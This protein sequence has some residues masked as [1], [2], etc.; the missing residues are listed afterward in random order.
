MTTTPMSELPAWPMTRSCPMLPPDAFRELRERPPVKVRMRCGDAWLLTRYQDVRAALADLRLSSDD[1]RPG[2]PSLIQLPDQGL[3]SFFRMDPP[4]A[5]RLR[6]VAMSEFTARRTR[7]LQ[8]TVEQLVGQLLDELGA[9]PRPTDLIEAFTLKL[10]AL[11]IARLLGVPDKDEGTFT[12]QTRTLLSQVAPPEETYAVY[13]AMAKYIDD[14]TAQRE[15]E[16]Q[17][18]MLSRLATQFV[19]TGQVSHHELVEIA[20]LLLIAGHETTANLLSL[21]ALSLLLDPQQRDRILADPEVVEAAVEEF[22]RYWSISQDNIVRVAIEDVEFGDVL[23]RAGEA[24]VLSIPAAN[25]DDRVFTDAAGLD[26]TRANVR[27]HVAFGFGPHL[28]PGAPLARLEMK[29]GLVELFRRFPT[30]RLA[31]DFTEL[32]FREKTLVYGVNKLP[33]TW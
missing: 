8:P 31:V 14:L 29:V 25:H 16:P 4:A 19:A 11:M 12:E 32:S 9:L 26:F 22:L 5:T 15:R 18:D 30:L 23:I 20:H 2:F 10:P 27:Q 1:Q 33:V 13:F 24:V 7:L 28:C 3:Q 6:K 17:D 21:S